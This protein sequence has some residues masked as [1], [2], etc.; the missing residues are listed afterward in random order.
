MSAD[1]KYHPPKWCRPPKD[2]SRHRQEVRFAKEAIGGS[3]SSGSVAVELSDK[4]VYT[5]GR[6]EKADVQLKGDLASRMH[7]AILQDIDGGKFLVDLKSTHGTF[8]D[9]KRLVPHS[10]VKW[11]AGVT[12]SLGSGAGRPLLAEVV[13]N[14]TASRSESGVSIRM[15]VLPT[16]AKLPKWPPRASS[17]AARTVSNSYARAG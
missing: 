10:P 6:S 11:A 3:A 12:A 4:A 5:I 1:G 14:A 2:P 7:A 8:M 9:A 16:S 13:V 17:A 15:A